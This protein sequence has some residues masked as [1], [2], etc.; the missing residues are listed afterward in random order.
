MNKMKKSA[1]AAM[2]LV[3]GILSSCNGQN[4]TGSATASLS[5]SINKH[6]SKLLQKPFSHL[7]IYNIIK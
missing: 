5:E 7:N 6:R 4:S 3:N 1:F 2:V